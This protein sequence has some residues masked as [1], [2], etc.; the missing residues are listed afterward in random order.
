MTVFPTILYKSPGKHLSRHG[1]FDFVGVKTQ[2]EFDAKIKEGWHPSQAAAFASVKQKTPPPQVMQ[3]APIQ[4]TD[5]N[6][7]P[8]R[9]ELEQKAAELGLKFDGRTTDKR[10]LERIEEALKG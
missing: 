4:P 7:P 10:L 8:T 9:E 6:M 1:M 5:E 2:S 3:P